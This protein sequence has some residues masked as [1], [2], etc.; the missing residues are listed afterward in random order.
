MIE[1]GGPL[2]LSR[3]CAL[4][5]VSR[6]SQY[7]RPKGERAENLAPGRDGQR[8]RASDGEAEGARQ[9]IHWDRIRAA[10]CPAAAPAG[11]LAG[12]GTSRR[13][14]RYGLSGGSREDGGAPRI[15]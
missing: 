2:S 7:H 8:C 10:A 9:P 11:P 13:G 4:L 6:S 5:G 12:V 14:G 3:Q 15:H 1:R